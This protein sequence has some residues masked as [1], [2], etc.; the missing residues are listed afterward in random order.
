MDLARSFILSMAENGLCLHFRDGK[1]QDKFRDRPRLT[2]TPNAEQVLSLGLL[3]PTPCTS[4]N[5]GVETA[6]KTVLVSRKLANIY[7]S[8]CKLQTSLHTRDNH[9]MLLSAPHLQMILT[10][11]LG[12]NTSSSM[13][14]ESMSAE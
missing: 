6:K 13:C 11:T 10:H 8:I 9:A 3:P 5:S 7:K 12:S 1:N 2:W 14:R 4:I